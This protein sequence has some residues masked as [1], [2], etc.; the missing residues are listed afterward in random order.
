MEKGRWKIHGIRL[1]WVIVVIW[2]SANLLSQA[3]YIGFNGEPYDAN[4]ILSGLGNWY[5]VCIAVELS[6]WVTLGLLVMNKLRIQ[7]KDDGIFESV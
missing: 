2:F 7:T 5:W 6:I 4:A 1:S 3:I